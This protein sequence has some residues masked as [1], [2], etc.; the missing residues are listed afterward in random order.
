MKTIF[1]NIVVF[2]LF[3]FVA[4]TA[5]AA[6]L[7]NSFADYEI[8]PVE[9]LI[10]GKNIEKVWTLSYDK[11]EMP[12]TIVLKKTAQGQEYLVHA[13][14]FEVVYLANAEGFGVREMRASERRVPKQITHAVIDAQQ[15]KYQE[16]ITPNSIDEKTALGL[17]AS[18]L[19]DLLN[20]GYK[21]LLN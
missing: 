12:V 6:S 10:L 7:G 1:S 9:N 17:I 14:F 8:T 13:E 3:S 5:S 21:H 19:P 16:I 4:F 15:L 11:E 20:E 18:Y 2:V